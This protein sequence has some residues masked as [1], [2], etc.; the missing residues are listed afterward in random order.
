MAAA[1][2]YSTFSQESDRIGGAPESDMT[3]FERMNQHEVEKNSV[4]IPEDLNVPSGAFS[5][6]KLWAFCGPVFFIFYSIVFSTVDS[7][8]LLLRLVILNRCRVF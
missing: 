5:W 2:E 3:L 1:G 8:Y 7:K 4:E 6:R